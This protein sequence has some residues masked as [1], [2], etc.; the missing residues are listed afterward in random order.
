[1][2]SKLG[3][4][5]LLEMWTKLEKLQKFAIMNILFNGDRRK[6]EKKN[7]KFSLRT[8][9]IGAL[10]RNQCCQTKLVAKTGQL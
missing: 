10:A 9:L 5:Q 8:S 1:M 4:G 2:M 7:L 3:G 6:G